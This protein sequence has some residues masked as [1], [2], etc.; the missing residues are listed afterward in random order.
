LLHLKG[1]NAYFTFLYFL[2]QL[3]LFSSRR[4]GFTR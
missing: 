2:F 3:Y 4:R 1:E